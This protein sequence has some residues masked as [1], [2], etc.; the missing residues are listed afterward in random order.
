MNLTIFQ[1]HRLWRGEVPQFNDVGKLSNGIAPQR[2]T[3]VSLDWC[4]LVR[5]TS[6]PIHS[7]AKEGGGAFA[8]ATFVNDTR[9]KSNCEAV[10]ALALDFDKGDARVE[11]ISELL[12]AYKRI[13]Y[14]THS[15]T[16]DTP[17]CRA[18]VAVSRPMS[19]DD[20]DTVWAVSAHNLLIAGARC[21]TAT[22][23]PSRFWYVPAVRA[24]GSWQ[25]VSVDGK[26]LDVDLTIQRHE[27]YMRAEEE[28]RAGALSSGGTSLRR[29]RAYLAAMPAAVSGQG[30]HNSAF[31]AACT[32]VANVSSES[33]Q[34]MLMSEFNDRCVPKWSARELSHKLKS[35]RN[36][37]DLEPLEARK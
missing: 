6:G 16:D 9:Y 23:D 20:Y 14:S 37:T 4:E 25:H 24:G 27:A 13:V 5:W 31:A 22:R 32:I 30:G 12:G 34:E 11:R 26:A 2:G 33:Q 7:E 19:V 35:A 1:P 8:M 10:Y 28:R 21:D 15:N 17:R 36:R 18:I 3:R 29:V